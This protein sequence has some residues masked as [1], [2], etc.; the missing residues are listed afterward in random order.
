MSEH[1]FENTTKT[2]HQLLAEAS[3]W[4]EQQQTRADAL[5]DQLDT[6][7][8]IGMAIGLVMAQYGLTDTQTRDVLEQLASDAGLAVGALAVDIVAEQCRLIAPDVRIAAPAL[9][10]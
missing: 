8:R 2:G 3:A 4:A 10:S 5:A 6:N 7:R 1:T 9:A